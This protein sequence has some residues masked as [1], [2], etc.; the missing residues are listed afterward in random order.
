MAKLN[1][2]QSLVL[3]SN[4]ILAFSKHLFFFLLLLIIIIIIII[5]IMLKILVQ[6]Y[7]VVENPLINTKMNLFEIEIF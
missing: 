1:F 3:S 5:I 6:I 4:M 2:Q 7:I